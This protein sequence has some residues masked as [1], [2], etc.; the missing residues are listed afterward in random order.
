MRL[1]QLYAVFFLSILT[2]GMLSAQEKN[3]ENNPFEVS[4]RTHYGFLAYHHNEMRILQ[5]RHLSAFEVAITHQ[6]SNNKQWAKWFGYPELGVVFMHFDLGSPT[7]LGQA[8]C[9]MPSFNFTLSGRGSRST[10][11]FRLA[12]GIGYVT[13]TFDRVTNYKNIGISTHL[14]A[15]INFLGEYRFTISDR[16]NIK[17]G[18][19]LTHLSNGSFKKPNAGLNMPTIYMG[20]GYRFQSSVTIHT[21]LNADSL[22]INKRLFTIVGIGGAKQDNPI[23]SK[24]YPVWGLSGEITWPSRPFQRFGVG[25]DFMHDGSNKENL[26]SSGTPVHSDIDV[27][28][29]GANIRYEFQVGKASINLGIGPYI[30]RLDKTG[31]PLYERLALRYFFSKSIFGQIALKTHWGNA[32]YVEYGLGIRL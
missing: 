7:Y 4:F 11:F 29:I 32:D 23:G 31:G 5:Q 14:N 15:A 30:Y 28:R 2:T 8:Y 22:N 21:V 25:L 10:F 18:L 27:T 16:L 3:I 13:K 24:R 17:T 20:I 26:I 6:P 19:A 12:P 9:I 1:K